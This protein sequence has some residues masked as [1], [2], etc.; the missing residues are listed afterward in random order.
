MILYHVLKK[1]ADLFALPLV[2]VFAIRGKYPWWM[3]TPDDPTSPFGQYEP[4]VREVYEAFGRYWGDVYW[5]GWRNRNYGIS[6]KYKPDWLKDPSIRYR[7]LTMYRDEELNTIILR[8]PDGTL[9]RE[10]TIKVGPLYII[11]GH[12]LRPIWDARQDELDRE[13]QGL[14]LVG[15]PLKRINMDCRPI[16]TIRTKRTL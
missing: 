3:V 5:L 14:P 15:W 8:Q 16:L 10:K 11:Y 9:L 12:R 4:T 6:Y 13:K 1:L 2:M 7:D